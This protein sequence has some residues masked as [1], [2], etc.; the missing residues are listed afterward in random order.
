MDDTQCMY[1]PASC[2][3]QP[4]GSPPGLN[5]VHG[6][7]PG[8]VSYTAPGGQEFYAPSSADFCAEQAAGKDNGLNPWAMNDSVGQGGRFDYQRSGKN[9]Y[10]AYT[11][12]ANFGV[13]VYMYGAGFSESEM[14]AIGGVYSFFKSSNSN[15]ASQSDWWGSG[16]QAAKNDNLG[17]GCR[18]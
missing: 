14:N 3:M 16:W 17:C 9:F 12:A 11:N 13:G 6:V 4:G 7:P 15:A 5:I 2:G 10:P 1:D 8:A 18:K